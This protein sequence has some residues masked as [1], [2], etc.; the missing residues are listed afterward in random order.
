MS[1][2]CVEKLPHSCG[3]SDGLQVFQTDKGEYNGF[4]FA[5][6]TFVPD[7]YKDKPKDFKPPKV[8]KPDWGEILEEFNSMPYVALPD[9]KLRKETLEYFDVRVG[10]SE[11]D[12]ETVVF[13]YYPHQ[14]V[15]GKHKAWS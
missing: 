11:A 13:H 2:L 1:G 6:S 14:I 10:L 7:P 9:R 3:T 15:T 8:E 5:C 4:C 12:G